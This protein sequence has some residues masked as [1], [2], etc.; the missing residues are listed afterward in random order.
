MIHTDDNTGR[1]GEPVSESNVSWGWLEQAARE[2]RDVIERLYT[3]GRTAV[4]EACPEE[5]EHGY[6]A[7][8]AAAQPVAGPP[9]QRSGSPPTGGGSHETGASS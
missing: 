1:N 3:E 5:R 6:P 7:T 8:A 9:A 2:A 4:A